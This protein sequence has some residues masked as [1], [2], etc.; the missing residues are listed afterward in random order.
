M[1]GQIIT[2][3]CNDMKELTKRMYRD[4]DN[5]TTIGDK[6]KSQSEG[7]SLSFTCNVV[8]VHKNVVDE[9][10]FIFKVGPNQ[11]KISYEY[12]VI[13]GFWK[14]RAD[15]EFV[16]VIDKAIFVKN[17]REFIDLVEEGKNCRL[18]FNEI[19]DVGIM[20]EDD[21]VTFFRH[22]DSDF[23]TDVS[24]EAS[25]TVTRTLALPALKHL[26]NEVMRIQ[27][28]WTY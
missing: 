4:V 22:L 18:D 7:L 14:K 28:A 9:I 20:T 3:I 25:L 2:N 10:I 24:G 6:L 23:H 5:L 13:N 27:G 11:M 1:E 8:T 21:K 15:P 16:D 26:A 12:S 17:W 19:K